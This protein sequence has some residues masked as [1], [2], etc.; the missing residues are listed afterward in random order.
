MEAN[1]FKMMKGITHLR[2]G[3]PLGFFFVG[4]TEPRRETPPSFHVKEHPRNGMIGE[5]KVA[6]AFVN[7]MGYPPE[8]AARQTAALK[9]GIESMTRA[10]QK[11][12]ERRLL[13][14]LRSEEQP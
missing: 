8:A 4:L 11:A 9:A 13:E 7:L 6:R 5:G 12:T 2:D 14:M 1:G 3:R 10:D